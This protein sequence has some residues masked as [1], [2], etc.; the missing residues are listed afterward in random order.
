MGSDSGH[1]PSHRA[2]NSPGACHDRHRE[3][4]G[5]MTSR[6]SAQRQRNDDNSRAASEHEPAHAP[7][8]PFSPDFLIPLLRN[9]GVDITQHGTHRGLSAPLPH[10][11]PH[12]THPT[13]TTDHTHQH[14]T[15]SPHSTPLHSTALY[16]TP[17]HRIRPR[18]H[19]HRAT[20]PRSATAATT[21]FRRHKSPS[22]GWP[23]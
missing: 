19:R 16:C 23:L 13:T 5:T 4:H 11:Q 21:C 12:D 3:G 8:P 10:A 17:L 1:T 7:I 9:I 22:R 14:T 2:G 18:R 15:T 20:P 6:T